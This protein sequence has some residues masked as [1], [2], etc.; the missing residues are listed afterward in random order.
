MSN[1]KQL[2]QSLGLSIT[3]VSRALDGYSD[4]SEAT[5][6]RVRRAA[7]EAGYRPNAAA[8]RLRRQRAELV[9]VPLP[10]APGQIG[11]PHFID[12]LADCADHLA[13]AGIHL[14][15]APVPRG[16]S[17]IEMCRRFVDGERVDAMVLVR[18]KRRDER[19]SF[20]QTRGIPFVSHGRTD[21][22]TPHAFIDGDGFS[23]FRDATLLFADGGHTH[24]GHL[25]A[26]Q[27]YTFAHLRRLGWENALIGRGLTTDLIADGDPTEHGGYA[28]AQ[29]LMSGSVKPTAILCATDEMAIGALRALREVE[30]G[31]GVSVI[32]H[33]NLP[34]GA[35]SAPP[36]STMH[37]CGADFGERLA[38][39][40][41]RAIAGEPPVDLQEIYPV[42]FIP[43]AS[44]CRTR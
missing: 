20:L 1:L 34:T 41:L 11:P 36:L 33:D 42:T 13:K 44:H 29:T 25:A 8:R 24:I 31:D 18:T 28:A 40:L 7:E 21:S 2:A 43:R 23:A 35:Y 14:V 9:A 39:L 4:V 12:M 22:E 5:R 6:Q 3:T 30:G 37:M 19:V 17:E 38:S 32:G 27:D 26:P 15:I 16:Q 10:S